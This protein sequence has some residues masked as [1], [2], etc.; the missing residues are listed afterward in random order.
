MNRFNP[1]HPDPAAEVRTDNP[2]VTVSGLTI[3][4]TAPA[5]GAGLGSNAA[6][7]VSAAP[8]S[9]LLCFPGSGICFRTADADVDLRFNLS[10]FWI[11]LP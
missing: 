11:E 3:G 1:L 5:V 2:T 4:G 10:F 8:G 9:P 6:L 7:A